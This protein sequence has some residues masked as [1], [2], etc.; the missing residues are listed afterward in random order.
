MTLDEFIEKV[1]KEMGINL[2]TAQIRKIVMDNARNMKQ[3]QS[4]VAVDYVTVRNWIIDSPNHKE[5]EKPKKGIETIKEEAIEKAE[6]R[7]SPNTQKTKTWE[8]ESLF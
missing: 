8:M 1:K 4:V 2:P 6:K 5:E 7:E 3:G